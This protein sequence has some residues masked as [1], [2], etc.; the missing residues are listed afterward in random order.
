M[1]IAASNEF[2]NIFTTPGAR[3]FHNGG[4]TKFSTVSVLSAPIERRV[5]I[6]EL[7]LISGL[8]GCVANVDSREI[9]KPGGTCDIDD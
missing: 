2:P 4:K 3:A 5:C 8:G 1:S 9:E 7:G 6:R